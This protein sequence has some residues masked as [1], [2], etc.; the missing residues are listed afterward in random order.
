MTMLDGLRNLML[1]DLGRHLER[2]AQEKRD[3]V[4][5]QVVAVGRGVE[6]TTDAYLDAVAAQA[7]TAE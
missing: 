2:L 3:D 5:T 1:D 6:G 4:P 7:P